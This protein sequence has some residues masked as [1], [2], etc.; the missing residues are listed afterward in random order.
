LGKVLTTP[1]RKKLLF[2]NTHETRCFLWRQSKPVVYYSPFGSKGGVLLQGGS[3]S[4]KKRD[5]LLGT[6]NVRSMYR[7]GSLAAAARELARYKLDLV[8]EQEVRWDKEGSVKAG[9]YGFFLWERK[10]K[11]S[12]GNKVFCTSQNCVS[13]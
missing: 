10:P 7:A 6:W 3:R 11:S 4:K 13:S 12:V 5:F 2:S 1:L 8:G 9:D